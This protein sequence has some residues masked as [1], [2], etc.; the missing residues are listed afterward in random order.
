[1]QAVAVHNAT[2][3]YGVKFA[4]RDVSFSVNRGEVV[5]VLGPNGCGKTTLFNIMAGATI[6]LSGRVDMFGRDYLDNFGELS[7]RVM[8]MPFHHPVST[9]YTP[10]LFWQAMGAAYGMA[11]KEVSRRLQH[12]VPQMDLQA[13]MH[14]NYV[15]LSLGMQRK[16]MLIAAFLPD[17]DVR[18]MDEPFSG[19]I[20]PLAMEVLVGWIM[21]ARERGETI[22]FSSQ[23]TEHAK[24]MADRILI[25]RAGRVA[26]YGTAQDMLARS[27]VAPEEERPLV[28]AYV[29]LAE[30]GPD[31]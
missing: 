1:M 16:V 6:P 22:V 14:K 29:A 11:Y 30:D 18:L 13:H 28:Q 20:D 31:E 10:Y 2:F 5:C 26:F 12:L 3:R 8:A 21:D 27:G 23:L 24:R 9:L 15:S 7:P 17:V 19:G 25:L 4:L